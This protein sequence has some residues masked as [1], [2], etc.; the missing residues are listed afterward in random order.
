MGRFKVKR[1]GGAFGAI[2]SGLGIGLGKGLG[3]ASTMMMKA[4]LSQMLKEDKTREDYIKEADKYMSGVQDNNITAEYRS[5]RRQFSKGEIGQDVMDAFIDQNLVDNPDIYVSE[6]ERRATNK[7]LRT[8][9]QEKV[10]QIEAGK[11]PLT[12][13]YYKQIASDTIAAAEE[14][15]TL[16]EYRDENSDV[17]EVLTNLRTR[18]AKEMEGDGYLEWKANQFGRGYVNQDEFYQ[19]IYNSPTSLGVETGVGSLAKN[20]WEFTNPNATGDEQKVYEYSQKKYPFET[21][22]RRAY[23]TEL[24][25]SEYEKELDMLFGNEVAPEKVDQPATPYAPNKPQH[26]PPKPRTT[27]GGGAGSGVPP[28]DRTYAGPT[29]AQMKGM[30]LQPGAITSTNPKTGNRIQML[31]GTTIWVPVVENPKN[32]SPPPGDSKLR[33]KF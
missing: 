11:G 20:K 16:Q 23:A 2:A 1:R 29:N 6:S 10:E 19:S 12:K 18:A 4:R 9:T 21:D 5:L 22:A 24:A 32:F 28:R 17:N 27:S 15:K 13:A 33:P 8:R 3:N 25:A 14:G 31:P 7:D 26:G 30:P